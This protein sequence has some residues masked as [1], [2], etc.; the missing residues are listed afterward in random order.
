MPDE[1]QASF[2]ARLL[3]E[4]PAAFLELLRIDLAPR[5]A[6]LQDVEGGARPAA[7]GGPALSADDADH[8]DHQRDDGGDDRGSKI[9]MNMQIRFP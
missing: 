8:E 7:A 3:A 2:L 1:S 5:E 4:Q 9:L 6:R